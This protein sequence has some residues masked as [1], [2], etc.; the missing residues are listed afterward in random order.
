MKE[1]NGKNLLATLIKLLAEQ[2]GVKI[3]YELYET[4]EEIPA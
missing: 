3:T 2:E 4:K 1:P